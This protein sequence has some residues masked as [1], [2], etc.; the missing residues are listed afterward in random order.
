MYYLRGSAHRRR[1][2]SHACLDARLRHK[3]Q[4][5]RAA[6]ARVQSRIP[7]QA[8]GSISSALLL[9]VQAPKSCSH[10]KLPHQCAPR[11]KGQWRQIHEH[12]QRGQSC[13]A[14]PYNW[15]LT[16]AQPFE[17]T[18]DSNY[19]AVAHPP[20]MSSYTISKRS[21]STPFSLAYL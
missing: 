15:R 13:K 6:G 11:S 5:N 16:V 19:I 17:Y 7:R 3:Q 8:V 14:L 18:A 1:W 2:Q 4:R 9:Q 21:T 10:S 20:E 12:L